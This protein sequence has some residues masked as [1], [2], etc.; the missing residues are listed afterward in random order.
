MP[1]ISLM[2]AP[3]RQEDPMI[4][5][6]GIDTSRVCDCGHIALDHHGVDPA[7]G[8]MERGCDC[9]KTCTE[10]GTIRP[11]PEEEPCSTLF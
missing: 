10:A 3:N 8:C 1:K 6:N 7:D 11:V 5:I 9:G 4:D 2:V